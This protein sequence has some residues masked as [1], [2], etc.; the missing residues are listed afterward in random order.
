MKLVKRQ[1]SRKL[2]PVLVFAGYV[3]VLHGGRG[4]GKSW[5]IAEKLILKAAASKRLILCA[6]EVMV[7]I[8]DSVHA[9]LADTIHRLGME[10]EF[11]ILKT[12]IKH[13][14]TGSRFIY[15]GIKTHPRKVK[16][17]EGVTD[18]WVEEAEAVSEESWQIVLPTFGRTVPDPQ[19]FVV[20]NPYSDGDPTT[21]RFLVNPPEGALVIEVNWWDN[22]WFPEWLR[23]QKDDDYRRDPAAARHTWEGKTIEQAG[24]TEFPMDNM[25][26]CTWHA[27]RF[28]GKNWYL[29]VD[30][31]GSK[32]KL[33]G[34]WTVMSPVGLGRDRFVYQGKWV[35]DKLNLLEKYNMMVN[36]HEQYRFKAIGYED[37]AGG[38]E[39]DYFAQKGAET[40]YRLPIV[41]LKA[42]K[43][44]V[45]R[46]RWLV[47]LVRELRYLIP[48][49][50]IYHQLDGVTVDLTQQFLKE[51]KSFPHI[52]D[53]LHDDMLDASS[54]I[55]DPD[56]QAYFPSATPGT[57]RPSAS[58]KRYDPA[59]GTMV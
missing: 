30:P 19:L 8:E 58:A 46:I 34:D 12:E 37:S 45:D 33:Y 38:I 56:L 18:L 54:R 1:V 52:P 51:M 16:G 42:T 39:I 50:S 25:K 5:V 47:P 35:R 36:L 59:T 22:P 7:S 14:V 29:L 6:R 27:D 24:T 40:G 3:V 28:D 48:Q 31:S 15:A 26:K 17:L 41:P 23:K 21:I 44:K 49:E 32:K 57:M 11:E 9:L 20:F 10:D 13:R 4:S 55:M 43:P 53:T 2:A